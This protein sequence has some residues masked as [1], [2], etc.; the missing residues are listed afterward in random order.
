MYE[1]ILIRIRVLLPFAQRLLF[2]LPPL[3][4][5]STVT[6]SF[7]AVLLG[8]SL[9]FR[10][11]VFLTGGASGSVGL[12]V[13]VVSG[14]AGSVVD[15]VSGSVGTGSGMTSGVGGGGVG[16][17]TCEVGA[18]GMSERSTMNIKVRSA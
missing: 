1:R 15:T 2:R 16:V 7:L 4:S 18:G 6:I 9:G 3:P 8:P 13:G 5:P 11:R 12:V 10:V 17:A 14:S